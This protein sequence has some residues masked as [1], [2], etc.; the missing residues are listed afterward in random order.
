MEAAAKIRIIAIIAVIAGPF[1]AYHGHQEKER[2]AN[3]DQE[4]VTVDGLIEGG[5]WRKGRRS[6]DY[7]F[8]VSFTP[9][10]SA[11]VRQ[12]FKVTS[13]FFSAHASD[14]A[15]TEPAIKVRYLPHSIQDSA[16]IVDGSPDAT[17][18]FGMGV[19]A[20]LLGLITLAVMHWFK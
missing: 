19:G 2:L 6:S 15:V 13:D 18:S 3:L 1:L 8:D 14:T 11:P 20:F 16:I 17:A 12:T 4:G 10:N 5:K 9:Q 7:K